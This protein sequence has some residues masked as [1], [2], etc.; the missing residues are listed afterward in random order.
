MLVCLQIFGIYCLNL[1]TAQRYWVLWNELASTPVQPE[2]LTPSYNSPSPI[3]VG[4]LDTLYTR[5]MKNQEFG[6]AV[7]WKNSCLNPFDKKIHLF[8]DT[9]IH[10]YILKWLYSKIYKCCL[11]SR[12]AIT[13]TLIMESEAT[14]GFFCFNI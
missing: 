13:L 11:F 12:Q 14:K 1:H 4:H 6:G 8:S 10:L 2:H 3:Q 7:R 9:V 5:Q